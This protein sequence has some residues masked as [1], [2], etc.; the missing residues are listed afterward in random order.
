MYF[1]NTIFTALAAIS[2]G[3]VPYRWSTK[4]PHQDALSTDHEV[5]L[6]LAT[7]LFNS[8]THP[9]Y[10]NHPYESF[11]E[12]NDLY[13]APSVELAKKLM[14]ESSFEENIET[15]MEILAKPTYTYY[16]LSSNLIY[17]PLSIIATGTS[18]VFEYGINNLVNKFYTTLKFNIVGDVLYRQSKEEII[19]NIKISNFYKY[20]L[21]KIDNTNKDV[22][23]IKDIVNAENGSTENL[24]CVTKHIN[25]NIGFY[26]YL[27]ITVVFGA[28]GVVAGGAAGVVAS[29]VMKNL[30][31]DNA[32]TKCIGVSGENLHIPDEN[33]EL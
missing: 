8:I 11:Q 20:S 12:L 9:K 31:F 16:Y 10:W 24:Y 30:A 5:K 29:Y 26:K 7:S 28:A 3:I 18:F 22:Q 2:L 27:Y 17:W 14:I 25:S 23:F 32:I 6:K 21:D 1:Y 19:E 13:G 4:Q 33:A 15:L